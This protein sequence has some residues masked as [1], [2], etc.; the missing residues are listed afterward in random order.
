MTIVPKPTTNVLRVG[1]KNLGEDD[2]YLERR[3][4]NEFGAEAGI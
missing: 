1:V 2:K 4:Q 3:E